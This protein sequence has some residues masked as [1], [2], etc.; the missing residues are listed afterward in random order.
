MSGSIP[1]VTS[2]ISDLLNLVFIQQ[3]LSNTTFFKLEP[4]K[5][6]F[7]KYE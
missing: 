7:Y 1:K 2:V 6:V 3:V 4:F 5:L